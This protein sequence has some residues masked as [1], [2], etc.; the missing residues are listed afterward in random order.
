MLT[1]WCKHLHPF[2][3]IACSLEDNS[4]DAEDPVKKIKVEFNYNTKSKIWLIS[5]YI[6]KV[7]RVGYN[8][9][10]WRGEMR[11]DFGQNALVSIEN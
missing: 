6:V 1:L 7:K 11:I 5:I 10:I 4:K 3:S 9:I 2:V 8:F